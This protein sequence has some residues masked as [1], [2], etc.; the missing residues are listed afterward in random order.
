MSRGRP[1][2]PLGTFGDINTTQLDTGKWQAETRM[3]LKSGQRKRVR[4]RGKTEKAAE[5][6]LKV[7]CGQL[8][9]TTDTRSLASTSTLRRLLEEW[10]KVH[11]VAP[12]TADIYASAIRRHINPAIGDI[13]LNELDTATLQDFFSSLRDSAARTSR[14][15]L[16]SA[17]GMAVRWNV[18][19]TNPVRETKLPKRKPVEA[20]ELTDE[21]ISAYRAAVVAWCG[22]NK[23]GVARGEGLVDIIDVC[24]G[25]GCRIGEVLALRWEDIDLDAGTITVAGTTDDHGGRKDTPKTDK[26]R[27]TMPVDDGLVK[28]LQARWD[29]PER[30]YMGDPV[31]PTITGGYRIVTNVEAQLRKARE[32]MTIEIPENWKITPHKFRSTAGTRIERDHGM[33]AAARW[34]GHSST[35]VTE[36]HYLARPKVLPNY[37]ETL[38][39]RP[40][41][42]V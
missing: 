15:V 36:R 19:E 1:A 23:Y 4:A 38:A 22:G 2:T 29:R 17:C 32:T 28:A 18:M 6:A 27:R 34:L 13:R 33:L 12:R 5:T 9:G 21:Q 42:A 8:T 3:R 20:V 10:A 40:L 39:R 7:K 31:F 24:I 30:E 35:A 11:D 41:R 14:A 37:S 25:T 26:S 16:G